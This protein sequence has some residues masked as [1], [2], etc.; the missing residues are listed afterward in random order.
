MGA[1][2]SE[3]PENKTAG[4]EAGGLGRIRLA[5]AASSIR[6]QSAAG[7][8][9]EIAEK[10]EKASL[11]HQKSVAL[12]GANAQA[13]CRR[14]GRSTTKVDCAGASSPRATDREPF[15]P[16][17]RLTDPH[18]NALSILAAHTHA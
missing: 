5:L 8:K 9:A 11:D 16:Q 2:S 17:G 10:A 13:D 15:D 7:R 6:T 18:R 3:A 12:N 14:P 4:F 1:R